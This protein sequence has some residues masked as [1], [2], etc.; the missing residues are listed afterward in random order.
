MGFPNLSVL[1][2]CQEF[3]LI[4]SQYFNYSVSYLLCVVFS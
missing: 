2:T 4:L 1:T 3:I